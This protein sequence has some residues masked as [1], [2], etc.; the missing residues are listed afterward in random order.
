MGTTKVFGGLYV[1]A[2][3]DFYQMAPVH[4]T[5]IFSNNYNTDSTEVLAPNLWQSHVRIYSLTEIMRQRNQQQFCQMLNRLCVGKNTAEDTRIFKSHIVHTTDANYDIMVHHIFPLRIPTDLHNEQIF[6]NT[7][8]T[9]KM[10]IT[11]ID[12]ITQNINRDDMVKALAMVQKGDKY[13]EIYGLRR[14]LP[15]AVGL[16]Y[17]VS[18][19]LFTEDGLINGATCVLQ[20][21]EKM[22]N[23]SEALP[24][25]LWV[26]FSDNNIGRK[27]RHQYRHLFKEETLDT[28]T[29]IFATTCETAVLNG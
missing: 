8:K 10:T 6:N 9:E 26:E 2:I 1:I 5:Y 20:K 27:T 17:S 3:G 12:K 7:K 28:W 24:K 13:S 16:V 4:D 19:N 11:A 23:V 25:L 29:P 18:C 14:Q 22:T 21:I 15:V